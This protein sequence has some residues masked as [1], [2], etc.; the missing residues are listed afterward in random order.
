MI[1]HELKRVFLDLSLNYNKGVHMGD[2]L[3]RRF[4]NNDADTV[5][6]L[7][8]RNFLEVNINDYSK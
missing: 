3:I 7:I 5:S 6:K 2:L 1:N 4:E 8:C